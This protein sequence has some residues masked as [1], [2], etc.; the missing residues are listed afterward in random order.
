[1]TRPEHQLQ[2]YGKADQRTARNGKQEVV[3]LRHRELWLFCARAFSF[4]GRRQQSSHPPAGT[5]FDFRDP[6]P[7]SDVDGLANR[8]GPKGLH[9]L[10][11]RHGRVGAP[12]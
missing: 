11:K 4:Q 12:E 10:A 2:P 6:W 3:R 1:M 5:S 7:R 9:M 8:R